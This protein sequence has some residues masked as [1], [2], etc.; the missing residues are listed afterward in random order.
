M[1]EPRQTR[2]L[3]QD[4]LRPR[5]D[6]IQC[7]RFDQAKQHCFRQ[8]GPQFILLEAGT[9]DARTPAGKF[10]AVA[11]D[12]ICFR[13]AGRIE[14]EAAAGTQVFASTILLAPPPANL[15][16]LYLDGVGLVPQ[17]LV[18]GASAA[19]MAS[20]FE[21]LCV[22]VPRR[23]AAHQ[24]RVQMAI[25][26]ILSLIAT[27]AGPEVRPR[28]TMDSWQRLRLRIDS[29]PRA[30]LDV[31]ALARMMRLSPDRFIRTFKKRF[32]VSPKA[33]HSKLKM[34]EAM[35]RLRAGGSSV[36]AI[37]YDLGFRHPRSFTRRF[38]EYPF[39]RRADPRA[40]SPAAERE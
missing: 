32:G 15:Y 28:E 31:A 6:V 19:E 27:I 24:L 2:Y 25:Y 13:P 39:G 14:Y 21:T 17:H 35:R 30:K 5:I 26:G 3:S 37:A 33:Y 16:P 8:P 38:R 23:G 34:Q 9:I 1:S 36:K 22:E 40:P 29:D 4:E 18:L 20:Y 11:G 10:R 7:W 12:L